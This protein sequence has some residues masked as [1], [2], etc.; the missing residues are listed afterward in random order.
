MLQVF[1][2]AAPSALVPSWGALQQRL[3]TVGAVEP[4]VI[5]SVL[6]PERPDLDGIVTLHRER[7]GWCPYSERVWLAL[8]AK[9]ADY[10]TVLIENSGFGARPSWFSGQ[11]PQ[12][13][14]ADGRMQGESMDLVRALDE[15]FSRTPLWPPDGLDGALVDKMVGDFKSCFPRGSR[16]SSRA[17]FLFGYGGE[18]LERATFEASLDATD[19]LL[20][21]TRGPWFAGESFSAADVAWAPFLERWAAQLP[22]LH[23]GLNVRDA[24]RWPALVAWFDAIERHVPAYA[25]R[26]AGDAQSWRRVLAM[27]GYGNAGLPPLLVEQMPEGGSSAVEPSTWAE[28]AEGRE[29]VGDTPAEEAAVR[30][31]RNHEAIAADIAKR[32]VVAD[33]AVDEAVREV[34]G[35]LAE[36]KDDDSQPPAM[37]AAAAAVWVHL[38]DRMC[39]PRDMGAPAAA[40]IRRVARLLREERDSH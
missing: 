14:W 8:E 3:P 10:A 12:I 7:H 16:P 23:A 2:A 24:S 38:D 4:R 11:T 28:Y 9:G 39:V 26:V 17:A 6:K 36:Q 37:S 31:V 22:C 33:G 21:S 30:V 20:S 19:D 18:P 27:A 1:L 15:H 25:C 40:V 35:L 29:H 13:R 34:A 32:E 5:D